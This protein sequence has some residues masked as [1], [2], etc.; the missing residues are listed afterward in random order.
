M[1]WFMAHVLQ[2]REYP[3]IL[4][5]LVFNTLLF[6]HLLRMPLGESKAGFWFTPSYIAP[7]APA[8]LHYKMGPFLSLAT[9]DRRIICVV[10]RCPKRTVV[11]ESLFAGLS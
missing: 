1:E 11:L 6:Q 4:C 7:P 10:R 3:L 8:P 2:V 5:S 9:G